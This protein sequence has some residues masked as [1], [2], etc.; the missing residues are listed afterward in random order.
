MSLYAAAELDA[1]NAV[2]TGIAEVTTSGRYD[3]SYGIRC[4]ISMGTL[5]TNYLTAGTGLGSFT[6]FNLRF[7]LWTGTAGNITSGIDMVRLF[8]SSG[9]EV[10]RIRTTGTNTWQMQYW[11]GS[12]FTNIGATFSTAPTFLYLYDLKIVCG[13][14]GSVE[15][16]SNGT[17]PAI[18]TGSASMTS[19]TN[20]DEF[21]LCNPNTVSPFGFS[22]IIWG[23]ESTIGQRYCPSPPTGNGFYTAG[24]GAFGDV[25]EAVTNDS[26]L[27]TLAAN[28]DAETYTHSAMTLPSGTVK[29]VQVT[30]RVKNGG[31]GPQNVKARLRKSSTDYD[32][33]AN[34]AGIGA[35]YTAYRARWA[36]DPA[37]GAAWTQA[38][39]AATAQEF[40]LVAQT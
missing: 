38:N 10:F 6:T 19:V 31:S 25:D 8:N 24:S 15:L 34:Y 16:Y 29:A 14:S 3:S 5:A 35:A 30:A 20:I 28:G 37:T 21:R 4:Y 13:G 12:S 11:N 18:A 27:S 26:D 36:T 2:G 33:G 9:T 23:D 39:A 40:G 1:I 7:G 17:G 22:E 32:Q